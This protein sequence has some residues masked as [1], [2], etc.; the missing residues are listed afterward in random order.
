MSNLVLLKADDVQKK[1]KG[2]TRTHGVYAL[3]FGINEIYDAGDFFY[4]TKVKEEPRD[5]QIRYGL[6]ALFKALA[7]HNLQL[8]GKTIRLLGKFV[9]IGST[10]FFE[11]LTEQF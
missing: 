8:D 1:W 11:P 9:K 10:V 5:I 3:T 4:V 2:Y 7:L 6:G